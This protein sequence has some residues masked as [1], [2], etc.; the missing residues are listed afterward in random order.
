MK[1]LLLI[2]KSLNMSLKTTGDF[3]EVIVD[4]NLGI[5]DSAQIIKSVTPKH[6]AL[7]RLHKGLKASGGTSTI[8]AYDRMHHRHNRN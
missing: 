3:L 2:I 5:A 6:P 4:Q 7:S 1:Y 8:T